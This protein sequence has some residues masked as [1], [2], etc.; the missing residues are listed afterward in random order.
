M[1]A[2][3]RERERER[4]KPSDSAPRSTFLGRATHLLMESLDYEVTLATVAGL[5]LPELGAWSIVDIVQPSGS[6]RRLAIVHPDPEMQKRA[7]LLQQSWPPQTEDQ[8]GAPVVMR[9]RKTQ[10]VS[11]VSDEMLVKFARDDENLEHLRK[12]GIASFLVVPLIV[13][14]QVSGAV[15]YVRASDHPYTQSDLGLADDLSYLSALAIEHA[16][17]HRESATRAVVAERQQKDLERIME[18]QAR[19]VRGFSHDVKNPLGAAQGYAQLLED[20]VI[21]SLTPGQSKSVVRIGASIRSALALI[22]DL[23][24]YARTKMG[25]VEVLPGPTNVG[26]LAKEIA[27]E[28]RAQIEAAGLD[29]EIDISL[30]LPVIQ[31]DG[32]R[33]RQILGNLLSNA[34][35]YTKQ[36]RVTVRVELCRQDQVPWSGDWM[37]IHVADT[38]Y[39]IR[40]EDQHLV[41][42]EFAR[43]EPTTTT[44]T[45]LGLAISQ[46]I[47]DA[48]GARVTL[49]SDVGKGS[50]FTLWLPVLPESQP[51]KPE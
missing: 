33:V 18:I 29:L 37:A 22:D 46:W 4:V 36:G 20:G 34:I 6:M 38:G 7:R 3:E 42:Q 15:T 8:I 14:G 11:H 50:T 43:L 25:K 16:R 21:D 26:D 28:Y 49:S 19:L 44:G 51:S 12:L 48:L 41:F 24:E 45:G 1:K 39:G 13:R 2:R 32:I 40:E 35:K 27:E 10:V 9:T 5:A 30:D 23:V 17:L 31:S 47:A